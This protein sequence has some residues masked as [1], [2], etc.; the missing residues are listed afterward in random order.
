MTVRSVMNWIAGNLPTGLFLGGT[1]PFK[2]TAPIWR[3]LSHELGI[4][5]HYGRA[6]TKHKIRHALKTG[7]DSMDSA[8]PLWTKE[9][10][11][12]TELCLKGEAPQLE[13]IE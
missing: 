3:D 7:V 11:K 1:T 10:W 2:N 5:F 4:L 6:G 12:F 9:R 8:F 13:L